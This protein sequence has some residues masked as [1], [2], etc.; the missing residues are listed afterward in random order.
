MAD[1][2]AWLM[3]LLHPACCHCKEA[4]LGESQTQEG[5]HEGMQVLQVLVLLRGREAVQQSR[6]QCC[7]PLALPK[8]GDRLEKIGLLKKRVVRRGACFLAPLCS[9]ALHTLN[10][11]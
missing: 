4:G 1:E 9:P 5:P 2:A 11:Q 6:V 7:I 8:L 3:H 10:Q